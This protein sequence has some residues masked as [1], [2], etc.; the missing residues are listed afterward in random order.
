MEKQE[1]SAGIRYAT[2]TITDK[3]EFLSGV[4][5][6]AGRHRTRIVCFDADRIAGRL[7]AEKALRLACRAEAEGTMIANSFEMEALLY[8]AGTRQCSMAVPFGIHE[9]EN[10]LYVCCCPDVPAAWQ[11]LAACMAFVPEPPQELSPEKAARLA[12]LFDITPDEIAAAGGAGCLTDL[13][14]ERVALLDVSK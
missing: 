7:H 1:F 12:R 10:R 4:H 5:A 11:D 6:V 9:K 8:A 3:K 2:I 13:V 14:L